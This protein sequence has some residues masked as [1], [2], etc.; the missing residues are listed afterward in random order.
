MVVA[1]VLSSLVMFF[2]A[3]LVNDFINRHPTFKILALSFLIMI[4]FLLAVEAFEVHVNKGYVYFAMGFSFLVEIV[5]M[6]MR[7]PTP[8]VQLRGPKMDE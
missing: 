5:N 6:R 1:V 3:K 4:G 2:F 7:K 8:P